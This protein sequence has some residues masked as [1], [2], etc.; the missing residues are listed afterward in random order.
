MND[1]KAV[2][3][4]SREITWPRKKA[5]I[6]I[7]AR[8][9]TSVENVHKTVRQ[10]LDSSCITHTIGDNIMLTKRGEAVWQRISG[11]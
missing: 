11:Q 8:G 2:D 1:D 3:R 4:L 9:H 5:I 10:W 7:G 6:E